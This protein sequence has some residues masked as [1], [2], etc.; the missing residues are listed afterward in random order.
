MAAE[1]KPVWQTG[2]VVEAAPVVTGVQRIVV[3]PEHPRRAA[4]GSHIDVVVDTGDRTD[5]RSYSV[6]ESADGSGLLTLGV[7]LAPR[8]RGG[9][10]YMHALTP[11]TEIRMTQPL[12]NFPL[13]IGADRYVLVAGGIGIT[14]IAGM[15]RVLHR[16]DHDYL[17]VYV[18][19]S[20]DRMA[21]LD[22][23]ER[24]HADR[25]R[26]HVD[27]EGTSLDVAALVDEVAADGPA[28]LYMCGPIP[29]MDAVRRSWRERSLPPTDLRYETFGNSGWFPSEEFTV[30]VPRLGITATVGADQTILQALERAG[31]EVLSDCRRGEC[32]LCQVTVLDVQGRLDHRDVFFD[33]RQKEASRRMCAC[34]SRAVRALP[35]A[36]TTTDSAS[37][38]LTLD[39]P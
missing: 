5:T 23:L 19:R 20:R 34:V 14:A 3:R 28:E 9:S 24:L 1:N 13:R 10:A 37:A 25:I 39:L 12:Q 21:Y 36:G 32:G 18:G 16:L 22:T 30:S 38:T 26:V 7:Q 29:L 2:Q 4:P 6:V 15:A 31:A 11:G 27:A 33:E 35:G 8:S 17:L